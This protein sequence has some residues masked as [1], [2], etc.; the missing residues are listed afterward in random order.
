MVDD[1][2]VIKPDNQEGITFINMFHTTDRADQ[3]KLVES[4]AQVT[5]EVIRYQPG[6]ISTNLHRSFDGRMV[7]NFARWNSVEDLKKALETP[8]MLAHREVLRGK[9]EREGYVGEIVYTYAIR[10]EE[11]VI[12]DQV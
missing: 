9:Y 4:L 11:P 10:S 3:E 2:P 6:F 5:E 12:T 8:G 7:T 1:T